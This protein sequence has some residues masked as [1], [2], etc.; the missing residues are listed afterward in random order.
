MCPSCKDN[1][2]YI[3]LLPSLAASR[4][5]CG[6]HNSLR[7]E[8]EL[9]ERQGP[10]CLPTV[11]KTHSMIFEECKWNVN[12]TNYFKYAKENVSPQDKSHVTMRYQNSCA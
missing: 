8:Q 2:I 10:P 11:A 1:S 7:L 12:V 4:A 5:L 3:C 6:P 9:L